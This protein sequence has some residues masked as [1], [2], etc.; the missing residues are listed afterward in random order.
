MDFMN[1]SRV[2]GTKLASIG[3]IAAGSTCLQPRLFRDYFHG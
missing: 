3:F 2:R 1:G